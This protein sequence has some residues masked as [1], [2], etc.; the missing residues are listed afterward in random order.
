MKI[1]PDTSVIVDGRV[2]ALVEAGDLEGATIIIP[3]PVVAEL[4]YQANAGYES[5]ISG[6]DEIVQLQH[7]HEVG[8]ITLHFR[9][10]RPTR[11][12]AEQRGEI[13]ALI[14]SISEES[15]AVLYTSDR[16]QAHI[17]SAKGLRTHYILPEQET[18]QARQTRKLYRHLPRS[19]AA[20]GTRPRN[21]ES[22]DY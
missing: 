1:V 3:E 20:Q 22:R 9:G 18:G 10:D 7:F 13:D 2:T 16:L 12:Q 21:T 5:G 11:D 14:R 8:K 6:L 19:Y 15:G 4:E 17:A